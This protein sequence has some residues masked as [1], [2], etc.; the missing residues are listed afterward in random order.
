MTR[1][2]PADMQATL[3]RLLLED[4]DTGVMAWVDHIS[5]RIENTLSRPHRVP[6]TLQRQ[7]PSALF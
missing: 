5:G 3:C 6:H 2:V 7:D 4:P 1:P